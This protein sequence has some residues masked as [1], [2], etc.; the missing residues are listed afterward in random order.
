MSPV[1]R[2]IDL[3]AHYPLDAVFI[4]QLSFSFLS[5]LLIGTLSR[6]KNV[7]LILQIMN[8]P[9]NA[10]T[11][12][13]LANKGLKNVTISHRNECDIKFIIL[14]WENSPL[15]KIVI[16]KWTP[17]AASWRI[18]ICVHLQPVQKKYPEVLLEEDIC[19]RSNYCCYIVRIE[20]TLKG[21]RENRSVNHQIPHKVWPRKPKHPLK[22]T[23]KSY[24]Q[25]QSTAEWRSMI[26]PFP[27]QVFV[28]SMIYFGHKL[29]SN[30][31]II[32]LPEE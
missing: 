31:R 13:W 5:C 18:S 15:G 4:V 2:P 7:E 19:R 6:C 30:L 20:G 23:L 17:T 10:L 28:P 16:R 22:R 12:A 32:N 9:L 24:L 14:C 8:W 29:I 25:I 3:L 11:E 26:I 27:K 1:K 21:W